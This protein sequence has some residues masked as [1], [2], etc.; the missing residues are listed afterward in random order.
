MA[1]KLLTLLDS[2]GGGGLSAG[3][4]ISSPS[5]KEK[6]A[7]NM[8]QQLETVHLLSKQ[9]NGIWGSRLLLLSEGCLE[10][11][12]LPVTFSNRLGRE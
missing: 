8:K 10:C 6:S 12:N 11:K 7:L 3:R 9:K 4:G 5:C 2:A 1:E